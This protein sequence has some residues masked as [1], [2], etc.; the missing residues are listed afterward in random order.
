V[1]PGGGLELE[2]LSR[3]ERQREPR[4][5]ILSE[6]GESKDLYAEGFLGIHIGAGRGS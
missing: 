3:R 4:A 5:E 2:A 6:L 1:V